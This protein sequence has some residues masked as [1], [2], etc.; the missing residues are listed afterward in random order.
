MMFH[1][2]TDKARC[3][4]VPK[5]CYQVTELSRWLEIRVLHVRNFKRKKEKEKLEI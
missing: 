4:L 5:G 2:D 1:V 3:V